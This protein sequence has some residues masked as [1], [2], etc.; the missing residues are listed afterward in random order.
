MNTYWDHEGKH[1]DKAEKLDNLIPAAGK[2]SGKENKALEKYRQ[3]A[4]L[5][6]EIFN[7]GGTNSMNGIKSIFGMSKDEVR[8]NVRLN[9]WDE[10]HS[11]VEPMLD[12]IILAAYKEQF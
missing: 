8:T 10:I 11:I 9:D 5:Y 4:N 2:V 6:Y 1:Q 12:K 3:A 7:N